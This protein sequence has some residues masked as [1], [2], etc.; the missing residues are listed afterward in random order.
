MLMSPEDFE[1]YR[2]KKEE[3]IFKKINEEVLESERNFTGET[4]TSK[5]NKDWTALCNVIVGS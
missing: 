5:R 4:V 2:N 1:Q 3:E